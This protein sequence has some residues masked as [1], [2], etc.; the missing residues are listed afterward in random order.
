MSLTAF[1]S[2][3]Q[4]EKPLQTIEQCAAILRSGYQYSMT[5]QIDIN[6][7]QGV[8]TISGDIQMLDGTQNIKSKVDEEVTASTQC[9][10]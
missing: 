9:V 3:S 10:I 8:Q 7:V 1:Q 4:Q 5:I 2:Y 6:R